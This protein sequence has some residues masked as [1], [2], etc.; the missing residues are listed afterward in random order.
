MLDPTNN[1]NQFV[2]DILSDLR[3]DHYHFL[4][5]VHFLGSSWSKS[6]ATAKANPM[7]AYSWLS[8]TIFIGMMSLS[9]LVLNLVFE[10]LIATLHILPGFL[11]FVAWQQS[12][13]YW[14][15]GLNRQI[16]TGKLLSDISSATT[17]TLL[18]GLAASYLL[19]RFIGE[20]STSSWLILLVF[21][22]GIITD[23]LDGLIARR[24]HTQTKYG[25]IADGE[26]DFCLY[27]A[28]TCIL[29]QQHILPFWFGIILFVRF[30]LPLIAALTSYVLYAHPA[31]FGST[32]WGKL[33]GLAVCLY[34]LLILA[35]GN[36]IT[37]TNLFH[38]PLMIVTLIL[39]VIAPVAQ[40]V[41]NV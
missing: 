10:G 2:V 4:A 17:V 14:H 30:M 25:Q 24:T 33:A 22:A 12:D 5:G 34:F 23:I 21:F 19:G 32:V 41:R 13:L 9:I 28:I 15:L 20:M 3:K 40:I 29:I 7:L 18:R 39:L 6:R 35:P 37:L 16:K 26:A 36:L 27:L 11:I 31:R 38:L 1:E 8:N